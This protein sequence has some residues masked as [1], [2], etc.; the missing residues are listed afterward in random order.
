[1]TLLLPNIATKAMFWI[2][3]KID[4]E[5]ENFCFISH[6]LNIWIAFRNSNI[7]KK[8]SLS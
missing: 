3:P 5:N 1:M 8:N 2:D 7:N 6:L 4:H